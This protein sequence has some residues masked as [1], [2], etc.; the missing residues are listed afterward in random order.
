MTHFQKSIFGSPLIS[1][2]PN[3]LFTIIFGSSEFWFFVYLLLFWFA[4]IFGYS[5]FWFIIIFGSPVLKFARWG[6]RWWSVGLKGRHTE[7]V[8]RRNFFFAIWKSMNTQKIGDVRI[9]S[10]FVWW[11]VQ[12]VPLKHRVV[13]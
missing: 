6:R 13:M 3:F 2:N 11:S 12:S 4:G 9:K 10:W 5:N 8:W 7:R 1:V